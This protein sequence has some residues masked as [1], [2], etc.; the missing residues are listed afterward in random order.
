MI[1][2]N[3]LILG[4]I[5]W[6][7]LLF[8]ILFV[9]FA[10]LLAIRRLAFPRFLQ[11]EQESLLIPKGFSGAWISRILYADIEKGWETVRGSTRT[12][13][14]QVKGQMIEINSIMLLDMVSY[15]AV[16]DFVKSR[17]IPKEKPVE[18][19][20]YGFWCS[21]VG[22]GE[23]YNSNGK[24]IWHFK[25]L[26]IRPH[27]PYGLFRVP[28]FVVCDRAGKELFRIRLQRKWPLARFEM[29]ENGSPICTFQQRS[30]LRNSFTFAFTDGQKWVFRMPLFTGRFGGL[31]ETG[32]KI[33]AHSGRT[34]NIWYVSIDE[35]VDS[36]QLVAA[37]AFIHRERLR[38]N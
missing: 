28:D 5:Y 21:Y 7:F 32:E 33:R 18:A 2:V 35:K 12:L 15:V 14:L 13:N 9:T 8:G 6:I 27:Y 10:L 31:S 22:N 37:L 20:K 30:F 34:H 23:I 38:F 29:I 25:T 16:R 26:H 11:L 24:V 36:P 4:R 17:V 19:G 1:Y 3:A